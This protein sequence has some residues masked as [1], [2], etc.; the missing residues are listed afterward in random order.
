MWTN[1]LLITDTVSCH[2]EPH[3]GLLLLLSMREITIIYNWYE[4]LLNKLTPH[5]T[6]V[7]GGITIS[8]HCRFSMHFKY[9]RLSPQPAPG[10]AYLY[11]LLTWR[12]NGKYWGIFILQWIGEP[13]CV[14]R[15]AESDSGTPTHSQAPPWQKPEQ[16]S[17]CR[18]ST[19]HCWPIVWPP[20]TMPSFTLSLAAI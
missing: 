15:F 11:N 14:V 20:F 12:N 10:S 6:L 5:I 18:P 13:K 9:I 1:I 17:L 2:T 3:D 7:K 4:L 16:W 8:K 19:R